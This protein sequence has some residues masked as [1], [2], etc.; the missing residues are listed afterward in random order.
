MQDIREGLMRVRERIAAAAARAGRRPDDV[1]LIAVSKTMAVE[2]VREA[3]EAGAS[4]LGENRVQEA[5]AKVAVLG[6]PVPWHLIGQLQTNKVKDALATFDVIQT[7][8][9][10]ELA[11]ELE[12]RA[13]ASGRPI[14]VFIEVNVASEPQKAG[15]APDAVGAALE[16]LGDLPHLKVRGLMAIPPAVERAEDA[17]PAFRVLRALAEKHRLGELSM[18]MSGDFEVAVEEGATVVRVGTAIFGPRQVT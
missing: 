17:R 13:S 3:I 15:F 8:D 2:R 6:H 7:V 5:K 4:A 18:G 16:A 1:L 12:K 14:D 11:R 10:L 9:R